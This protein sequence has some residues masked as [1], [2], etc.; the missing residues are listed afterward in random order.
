MTDESKTA[1]TEA[2]GGAMVVE[3]V[4]EPAT[5]AGDEAPP[6]LNQ[7]VAIKD[8]GPCKKHV[9]VTIVR[10]D[11]DARLDKK[12]SELVTDAPVA[13]FRPG[14]APRKVIERRFRKDVTDQVKGELLLESLEQLDK[15][16]D[17]SP[18]SPPDLDPTK[19]EIPEKGPFVYEFNVEVRP[20]FDLP[21]YKGLKLKRPVKT[22]TDADVARE[23]QKLLA[24]YGQLIPKAAPAGGGEPETEIGDYLIVDITMFVGNKDVSNLKEVTVRVDDQLAFK[25]G[26]AENFGEKLKG[27]KAGESRT[28]DVTLSDSV[29]DPALKGHKLQAKFDVK[30]VKTIRLPEL[31]HELCHEFG[32]HSAEQLRELLRV[33][34]QRRL[35]YTQ[36]Q[37]ARQQVLQQIAVAS[38][39]ELPQDMLMRQARRTL[40][41]RIMEMRS[42]GIAEDEIKAR[43]RLMERDVLQST[44]VAL[45]EQF[46][47]Q[48]IADLEKLDISDDDLNDEIERIAAQNEES[49]R[50]VRA[51]LEKEDLLEALASEILERKALDLV[52][53]HAEYEDV[54]L[55]QSTE[56][57][58]STIEEQAVQGEMKD[59]TIAPPA[60][61]EPPATAE[62][63]ATPPS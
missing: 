24:P 26:V 34:L 32:V 54:P 13:G 44:A 46:V 20:K 60:A 51:R 41:S 31:T 38:D 12:Y 16:H 1:A 15:E 39:W 55:G 17:L 6:K 25:D 36:R 7:S 19:I 22:F 59:P 14:K 4:N 27:A 63:P 35:E 10:E 56:A 2:E 5:P 11:I 21:S 57:A 23:E 58:V 61:E 40:Y 9:Q 8:V 30:D 43:Q 50:R 3:P 28:V 33:V 37:S 42:S 62:P 49:P 18:L 53:Q 48:K 29:A 52:L 45:K 47:M